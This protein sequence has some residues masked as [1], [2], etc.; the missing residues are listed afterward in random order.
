MKHYQKAVLVTLINLGLSHAVSAA[1]LNGTLTIT[2]GIIIFDEVI[3]D[4]IYQ[5]GSYFVM[6]RAPRV[7]GILGTGAALLPGSDGGI[8]LGQYQ[9]FV[10]D[11]DVPHPQGWQGDI[12]GDGIPDGA[13]GAGYGGTP[14][15]GGGNIVQP[16]SFAGVPTYVGTNPISYQSGNGHPAPSA[17]ITNCVGSI[18]TLSLQL[19]SWEVMWN[20]SAFEQ[21]PR[22]VNT[23]PFTLATGTF[24]Q[25]N[26]HYSV[27]WAS[28]INGGPFNGVTTRWY[29]EGVL[30][31]V[32]E[33]ATYSMMAA[34]LLMLGGAWRLKR[35]HV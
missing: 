30:V 1:T 26:N 8:K 4:N 31:P 11:P 5:G 6:G 20:G 14:V 35:R 29:L 34:G 23:G 9:N 17:E 27:L 19:E 12:N 32:P 28:Q 33:P 25:S 22:P 24:D 16:F 21:G 18:C 13:A 10:L 7:G 15:S 3:G 2:P